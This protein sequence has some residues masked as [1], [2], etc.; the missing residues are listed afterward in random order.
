MTDKKS[1]IDEE[2]LLK[3]DPEFITFYNATL[4]DKPGLHEIPWDPAL[5]NGPPIVGASEPLQVGFTEDIQLE[6][7]KIR[8]FVPEPLSDLDGTKLPALLYFHG[9]IGIIHGLD[10]ELTIALRRLDAWKY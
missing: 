2:M 3:L 6:N 4:A 1:P 10:D 7:C 9:G 8:A 5:R